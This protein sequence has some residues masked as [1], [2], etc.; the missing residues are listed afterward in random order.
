VTG[1]GT[2]SNVILIG[3]ILKQ[4][5]RYLAEGV[6]P[7]ILCDGID[8]GKTK[9]LAFLDEFKV[10]KDTTDREL[11]LS[12]ARTSLR[13]KVYSQLADSLT[14]AVV[15]A[16]LTIRQKDQPLDLF[17]VEVMAM[18]H[19]TDMDTKLIKGLVLDH[20]ARHP[21]MPKRVDNAFILTCNVG[22]EYEKR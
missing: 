14:E 8:A 9:A 6:H 16:V 18:Q 20:G 17:M 19:K 10:K 21:D 1:D 11:L 5:E 3:E 15:D 7:R 2:S 4:C 12:V 13:T 22:L